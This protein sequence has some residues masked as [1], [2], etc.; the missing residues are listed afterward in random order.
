VNCI[1]SISN[2]EQDCSVF[3][4]TGAR[5][6]TQL[7]ENIPWPS[8]ECTLAGTQS[9]FWYRETLGITGGMDKIFFSG[10]NKELNI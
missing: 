5:N 9:F 7:W 6:V 4:P 3:H 1:S 10:V 2:A 8:E